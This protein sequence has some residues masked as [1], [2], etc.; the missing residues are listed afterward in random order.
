MVREPRGIRGRS[1]LEHLEQPRHAARAAGR[2]RSRPRSRVAPARGETTRERPRARARRGRPPRREPRPAASTSCAA[3]SGSSPP[4]ATETR[5]T[6]PRASAESRETRASTASVTLSGTVQ[7]GRR[8][9]LGDVERVP[10][11]DAMQA[12][13]SSACPAASARTPAGVSAGTCNRSHPAA[14]ARSPST[15]RSGWPA[16]TSSSR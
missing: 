5:S 7:P 1:R 14:V 12:L 15:A 8:E 9:H 4:G 3:I 6:N 2:R 11:R 13:G 10:A 16:P